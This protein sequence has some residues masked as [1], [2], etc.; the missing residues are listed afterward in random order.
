MKSIQKYIPAIQ[1]VEYHIFRSNLVQAL[2]IFLKINSN[3]IGEICFCSVNNRNRWNYI[4]TDFYS[5]VYWIWSHLHSFGLFRQVFMSVL[6]SCSYFRL[7]IRNSF[8]FWIFVTSWSY[9][10]LCTHTSYCFWI[11][12]IDCCCCWRLYT[13]TGKSF[14]IFLSGCS[15]NCYLLLAIAAISSEPCDSYSSSG[16]SF[17]V[18][19]TFILFKASL[20]WSSLLFESTCS[21]SSF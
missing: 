7:S 21:C 19:T 15:C 14:C 20:R 17:T 13:C 16:V 18:S 8:S 1:F 6:S 2:F 4:V 5:G 3:N 10:R 9:L 12:L 11:L